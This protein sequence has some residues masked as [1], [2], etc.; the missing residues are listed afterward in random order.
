MK[1]LKGV[2]K[3]QKDFKLL[4]EEYLMK[5]EAKGETKKAQKD[6]KVVEETTKSDNTATDEE[7]KENTYEDEP[8]V[9]E[10]D[11]EFQEREGRDKRSSTLY[12]KESD[13]D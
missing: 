5:E 12:S 2:T 8:N 6:Q 13:T 1:D 7:E 3:I 9:I 11:F 4:S 10:D